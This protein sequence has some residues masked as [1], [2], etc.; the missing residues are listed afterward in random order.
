[1]KNKS[2]IIKILIVGC[3]ALF[4]SLFIVVFMLIK[5]IMPKK[6]KV[7]EKEIIT[8][9]YSLENIK[10][11]SFDFRKAS[12]IFKTSDDEELVIVQDT[13]EEKFY[14]NNKVKNNKLSFSEDSYIIKPQKKKYII[15]IPKTYINNITIVNGFGEINIS[16]II[17]NIDINNNAGEV[18][19]D[20]IQNT[21][22]KSVSGNIYLGNVIGD[23]DVETSTGNITVENINGTIAAES[24]AGDI[25][26]TNFDIT[27]NSSFENV[28]GGIVLKMK[29]NAMCS[30]AYSNETGKTLID[31]NVCTGLA[32]LI[33]IKNMTG[34]IKIY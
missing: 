11:I 27:G 8:Q 12:A 25:L 17:N 1:M 32:N 26:V 9:N 29:E 6:E 4:I 22:I 7:V 10:N 2:A 5:T 16:E 19:L 24:I 34:I 14:L 23:I 21:K 3:I 28:S 30:L 15:Y 31:D 18:I 20:Q 33:Y 13:K